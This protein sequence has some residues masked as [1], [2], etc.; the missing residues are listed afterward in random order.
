MEKYLHL[1][2][3]VFTEIKAYILD[4]SE[5]VYGQ[6]VP[7]NVK[8]SDVDIWYCYHETRNSE[9]S[10]DVVYRKL[11]SEILMQV[12][13][14]QVDGY[15]SDI[16]EGAYNLK[17]P[18]SIFG[19]KG[20]Y[21]VYIK[22]REFE[23]TIQDVGVLAVYNDV[24][25][26][27]ID[28]TNIS[29]TTIRE[30]F[31]TNNELEGY[32]VQYLNESNEK[33][34]FFRFVTSNNKCE[35]VVQNMSGSNQKAVRYRYNDNSNLV[36]LTLTPSIAPS[37]KASA[38]PFIG[39]VGQ[40]I[41]ISNTKF[42]PIFLDLEMVDHDADTISTMLEG[43]QLRDW[44]KGLVTTFNSDNEIYH[45][46]ESTSLKNKYTGEP[47][48]EAKVNKTTSIDYTQDINVVNE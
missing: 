23:I 43:S 15:S 10:A 32:R 42:T 39:N 21:S 8:A 41:V 37:F 4:M 24:R 27:V 44:D 17:L 38:T 47:V 36:F 1:F 28:T 40:R 26:I 6:V 19:K 22:P 13:H 11:D 16:L 9:D 46:A 3:V 33:E 14:E 29:D 34:K 35:P 31:K 20:F 2:F 5:G 7:A 48:Y 12:N 30:M 25:G 18:T 45:Q